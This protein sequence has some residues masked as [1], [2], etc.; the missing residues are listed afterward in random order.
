MRACCPEAMPTPAADRLAQLATG[1]L[2]GLA[3]ALACLWVWSRRRGRPPAAAGL[4]LAVAVVAGLAVTSVPAGPAVAWPP[5][6]LAAAVA[7]ALVA[8]DRRW[9]EL[10]LLPALLAVTAAG[11]WA[12]VPDVEAALVLLGAALAMALLGRPGPLA[13]RRPGLAAFGV[14]GSVA[15]AAVLVWTVTTGGAARPGSVVGGL[16]CLGLLAVEPAVRLLDPHRRSPLDPLERRP[17]LAWAAVAIQLV[18][19]G[20]AARVVAR[21][22]R[23]ATALAL[24]ALELG[25]ALAAGTLLARRRSPSRRTPS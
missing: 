16:A 17:G 22:E 25:L 3:A 5:L 23:A 2:P 20:L 18:L 1:L 14:A 19:A 8:F 9:R 10:G 7:A 12:A 15:V 21:P 6:A 24:A 11:I 13:G 4:A